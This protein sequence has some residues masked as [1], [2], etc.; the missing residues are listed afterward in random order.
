MRSKLFIAIEYLFK[1][2]NFKLISR[3]ENTDDTLKSFVTEVVKPAVKEGIGYGLVDLRD[4]SRAGVIDNIMRTE[5]RGAAFVI[6]DLSHDNPGTYWEGGYAEGLGKPVVYLCEEEKFHD[7]ETKP[8]FDT[9]YYTTILWS[10][11]RK[12]DDEF[13]RI[14][15]A[16][17]RRSL[18]L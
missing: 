18:D 3:L 17:L 15:I 13:K 9:N 7:A 14:L 6:S 11:S 4:K 2:L 1:M 10:K 5:I 8:H 16:T 12:N